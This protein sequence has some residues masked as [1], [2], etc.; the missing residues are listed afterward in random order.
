M[1]TWSWYKSLLLNS[2]MK[3]SHAA[4]HKIPWHDTWKYKILIISIIQLKDYTYIYRFFYSMNFLIQLLSYRLWYSRSCI[5]FNP[6][7]VF[8]NYRY[9]FQIFA[10]VKFIYIY[11]YI[12]I[13]IAQDYSTLKKWQHLLR[14][15]IINK[16]K[17]TK[18]TLLSIK[19]NKNTTS[20]KPVI[21]SKNIAWLRRDLKAVVLSAN[22]TNLFV[23]WIS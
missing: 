8:L 4:S 2:H 18:K 19:I 23:I 7:Q 6:R 21:T 3:L 17:T 14:I 16:S 5:Q 9:L 11:I 15:K 12:K 1:F 13:L 20:C 22:S 10:F